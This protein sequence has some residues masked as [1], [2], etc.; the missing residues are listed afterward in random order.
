LRRQRDL[1]AGHLAWLDQEIG[2]LEPGRSQPTPANP[3]PTAR[4]MI[5]VPSTEELADLQEWLE[6]RA[7]AGRVLSK[8]GCWI[9]FGSL[10]ML[11]AAGAVGLIYRLYP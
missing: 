6:P 3:D 2:R 11:G 4:V 5:D 8:T 1:V 7:A 10:L 9:I